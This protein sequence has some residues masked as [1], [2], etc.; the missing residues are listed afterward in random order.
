MALGCSTQK[1]LPAAAAQLC[2][3][4]RSLVYNRHYHSV[5]RG[6]ISV[7]RCGSTHP[8]NA[9]AC[10][11]QVRLGPAPPVPPRPGSRLALDVAAPGTAES[12][13]EAAANLALNPNR[14][15]WVAD[16]L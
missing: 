4:S 3:Y 6:R 9:Y 5:S 1:S 15:F 8:A 7:R 2:L 12:A 11:S 13:S 16:S 14:L 10:I